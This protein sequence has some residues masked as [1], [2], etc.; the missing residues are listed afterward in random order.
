ML[1]VGHHPDIMLLSEIIL[2]NA[3]SK[4]FWVATRFFYQK[5]C[6][7]SIP[8]AVQLF[9]LLISFIN[10]SV[11]MSNSFITVTFSPSNLFTSSIQG[12]FGVLLFFPQISPQNS[13]NLSFSFFFLC[14]LSPHFPSEE[15]IARL[16]YPLTQL[17]HCILPS[18]ASFLQSYFVQVVSF[19][20]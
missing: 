4:A 11:S 20:I 6:T 3:S 14:C 12:I 15:F 10:F 7:P 9:L 19:L 2:L 18:L 13:T 5:F 1:P 8:G 17:F 16:C